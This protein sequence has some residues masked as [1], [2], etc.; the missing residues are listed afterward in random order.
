MPPWRGVRRW[1]WRDRCCWRYFVGRDVGRCYSGRC[2]RMSKKEE[3]DAPRYVRRCRRPPAGIGEPA[4]CSPA[5]DARVGPMSDEEERP[6]VVWACRRSHPSLLL[7]MLRQPPPPPLHRRRRVPRPGW[8]DTSREAWSSSCADR[9]G[10]CTA[11][12]PACVPP[13]STPWSGSAPRDGTVPRRDGHRNRS[14]TCRRVNLLL[15]L[16]WRPGWTTR[17]NVVGS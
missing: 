13:P 6:I 10:S 1:A 7:W 15:L 16:P 14:R 3:E 11:N 4:R 17:R 5:H 8:S 12:S 2:S 9:H